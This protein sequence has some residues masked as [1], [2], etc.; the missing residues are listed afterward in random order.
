MTE[1]WINERNDTNL[2]INSV[3]ENKWG[4]SEVDVEEEINSL[5]KQWQFNF[6]DLSLNPIL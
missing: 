2:F 1:I 5:K 6:W 4:L 3:L